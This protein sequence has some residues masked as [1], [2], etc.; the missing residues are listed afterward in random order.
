LKA[1][2]YKRSKSDQL[3]QLKI[4]GIIC[5]TLF[6]KSRVTTEDWII[7]IVA[8]RDDILPVNFLY[9]PKRQSE[10]LDRNLTE[11]PILSG[12]S[13][14]LTAFNSS[15]TQRSNVTGLLIFLNIIGLVFEIPVNTAPPRLK[16]YN[17][18]FFSCLY[19]IV[20]D[21]KHKLN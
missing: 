5:I 12:A 14:D 19:L 10:Y 9:L 7:L 6:I 1:N 15:P 18:Y 3:K 20:F 8:L 16:Y 4:S 21:A 17:G 11:N 2:I 13:S